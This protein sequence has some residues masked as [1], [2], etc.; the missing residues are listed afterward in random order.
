MMEPWLS[1]HY[2]LLFESRSHC[3]GLKAKLECKH[4]WMNGLEA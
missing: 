2:E 4:L 1:H 3:E